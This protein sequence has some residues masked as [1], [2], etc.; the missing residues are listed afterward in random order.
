MQ[1]VNAIERIVFYIYIYIF[2]N[3]F[4]SGIF[5]VL[6]IFSNFSF[7]FRVFKMRLIRDTSLF[8]ENV[9]FEGPNGRQ[10]AFD[11]MHAYSGTL[12]GE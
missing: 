1:G 7:Y 10:I 9:V 3:S 11:P 12:E 2:L 4:E 5:F 6:M 8:H